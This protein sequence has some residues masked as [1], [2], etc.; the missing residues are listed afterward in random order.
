MSNESKKVYVVLLEDGGIPDDPQVFADVDD[1]NACGSSILLKQGFGRKEGESDEDHINAY[2]EISPDWW[3]RSEDLSDI[4]IE[5]KAGR[6]D[7]MRH[8]DEVLRMWA[9]DLIRSN[10]EAE[11]TVV[12]PS[13]AMGWKDR[14]QNV[15]DG[16]R[17]QW[18]SYDRIYN[19]AGRLGFESSEEAWEANPIICGG[20]NPA[21]YGLLSE[22]ENH[23]DTE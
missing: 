2:F 14:L 5:L 16:D 10:E 8:E 18:D 11:D 3:M 23:E 4:Q 17:D 7:S 21:D 19:L 6:E 1:W 12:L 13:G 22:K 15:Y 20:S 9:C